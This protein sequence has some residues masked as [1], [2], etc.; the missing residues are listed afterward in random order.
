[1]G[2]WQASYARVAKLKRLQVLDEVM[3]LLFV[4]PRLNRAS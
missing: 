1:M 4:S 3:L 2:N